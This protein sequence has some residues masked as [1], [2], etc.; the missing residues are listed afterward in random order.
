M[1][2]VFAIAALIAG[3]TFAASAQDKK[4]EVRQEVQ[5]ERKMKVDHQRKAKSPEE[6]AKLKTEHM[7]KALKLTE[8][9]KQ[10]IYKFHLDKAKK[11][12]VK[13]EEL[14]KAREVHRKEM[15]AEHE[16][17]K[18]LL[19]PEQQELY[20]NKLAE[21]RKYRGD[22]EGRSFKHREMRHKRMDRKMPVEKEVKETNVNSSNS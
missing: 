7:D 9:Q 14:M 17:L 1:K 13:R 8:Q 18:K 5:K 22:R 10:D 21:G 4:P 16:T 20:K 19:T 11:L 6:V 12:E 15:R 3:V 2:K